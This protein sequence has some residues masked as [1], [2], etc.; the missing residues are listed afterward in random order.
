MGRKR[1]A[2]GLFVRVDGRVF[3]DPHHGEDLL[4]VGREAKGLNRLA[5]LFRGDHHLYD[6]GDAAGVEIIDFGEVEE[7][8][9][10]ALG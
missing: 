3:R 8:P 4:K 9:A 6:E 10:S 2:R 7:N 1:G 5:S